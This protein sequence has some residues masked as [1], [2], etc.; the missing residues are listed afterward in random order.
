MDQAVGG[1]HVPGDSHNYTPHQHNGFNMSASNTGSAGEVHLAVRNK[2]DQRS[3]GEYCGLHSHTCVPGF[4]M[5][6]ELPGGTGCQ[7]S[8]VPDESIF[9]Q[10]GSFDRSLSHIP[11]VYTET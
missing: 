11:S 8:S 7:F 6:Q 5:S 10:V 1:I 9:F 4:S 2:D 3:S